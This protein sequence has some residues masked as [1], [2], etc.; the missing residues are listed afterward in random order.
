M[1]DWL[2]IK[3]VIGWCERDAEYAEQKKKKKKNPDPFHQFL[4]LMKD[5]E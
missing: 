3:Y 4:P 1:W 5:Q 2:I